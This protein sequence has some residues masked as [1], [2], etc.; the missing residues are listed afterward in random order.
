[1]DPINTMKKTIEYK[2][3]TTNDCRDDELLI[4]RYYT[5]QTS[6]NAMEFY[7]ESE[8]NNT[9]YISSKNLHREHDIATNVCYD[10]PKPVN[11]I[12]R[13]SNINN[14]L[15]LDNYDTTHSNT[16]TT[17]LNTCLTTLHSV[18][19]CMLFI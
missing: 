11:S 7:D 2:S 1:M 10:K 17:N 12:R 19:N 6:S 16:C 9:Y 5:K 18:R 4:D 8:L 14:S 13:R 15:E 3:P